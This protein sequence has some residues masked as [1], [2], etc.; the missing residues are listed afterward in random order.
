VKNTDWKVLKQNKGSFFLCG[1]CAVGQGLLPVVSIRLLQYVLDEVTGNNRL[2]RYVILYILLILLAKILQN[3]MSFLQERA[4]MNIRHNTERTEM[5]DFLASCMRIGVDSFESPE[6]YDR[7]SR[8]RNGLDNLYVSGMNG[9]LTL[10]SGIITVIG[11]FKIISEAGWQVVLICLLT[12]LP[13]WIVNICLTFKENKGWRENHE[14]VRRQQ[15]YSDVITKREHAKET[16]VFDSYGFFGKKWEHSY[17]DYNRKL[18]KLTISTRLLSAFL[19]FL[20]GAGIGAVICLLLPRLGAGIIT[21]GFLISVVEALRQF[22]N[23]FIWGINGAVWN[24]LMSKTL[25]EDKRVLEEAARQAQKEE[26]GGA[27]LHKD[28]GKAGQ[29]VSSVGT[30]EI[31]D[32]WFRYPGSDTYTLKGISFTVR[33]GEQIALVGE[34]GSGKSTLAKL[35]LG[36]YKPEKGSIRYNGVEVSTLTKEQRKEVFGVVFQD[37]ARYEITLRENLAFYDL[38][39]QD[40]DADY[41]RAL[42]AVDGDKILSDCKGLDAVLGKKI[43]GGVDLSNGQW[44]KLAIARILIHNAAF[45]ILDEPSS[46][47]DPLA[48][49][50]I[51]QQYAKLTEHTSGLLITHR[52]GSIQFCSRILVLQNGKVMEEGTHQTLMEVGGIYAGMY[53]M[54]KGW[55]L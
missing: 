14:R 19:F 31:D 29:I 16:R 49:V 52:L 46:A 10:A 6:L 18:I 7:I 47:A 55:Y 43:N 32:V 28:S 34:N 42:R 9:V 2:S 38:E 24:I 41:I 26:A 23:D 5:Q 3:V 36:L 21:I 45:T 30:M 33:P 4:S 44:Q 37:Y 8:L 39:H 25:L 54:Q 27:T 50:E 15:Y 22:S 1:L 51:Y 35:V 11:V 53:Q 12:L 40:Q 17:D 48:E 20:M 13:I